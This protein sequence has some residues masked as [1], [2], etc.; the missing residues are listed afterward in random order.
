MQQ[1][2]LGKFGLQASGAGIG[3]NVTLTVPT[4]MQGPIY[5]YYAL[6]NFQQNH[7]RYASPNAPFHRGLLLWN[8]KLRSCVHLNSV[9]RPNS[10]NNTLDKVH[11]AVSQ[12]SRTEQCSL[13]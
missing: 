1:L 10:S 12:H 7:R 13:A 4:R 5:L 9:V 2:T 6:D 8:S 3:C 11:A